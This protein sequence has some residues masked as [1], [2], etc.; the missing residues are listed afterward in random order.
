MATPAPLCA[1]ALVAYASPCNVFVNRTPVILGSMSVNPGWP[2]V[3]GWTS[4]LRKPG[5]SDQAKLVAPRAEQ[6]SRSAV[7]SRIED[8][9]FTGSAKTQNLRMS[10][11]LSVI[12]E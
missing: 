8:S 9:Q 10:I 1:T 11:S 2:L 4:A 3:P 12:D 7:A 6:L 5:P